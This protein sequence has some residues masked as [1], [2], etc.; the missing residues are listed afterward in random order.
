MG[1]TVDTSYVVDYLREDEGALTKSEELDRRKEPKF[2]STPV[3]YE[4]S[5]GLLHRRSRSETAAFRA[6]A[7]SFVL[8]PFDETAAVLA[9]EVRAE[10]L[11]LGRVKGN[12]DVMIAGIAAAGGHSLITRDE[13]FLAIAETITLSLESY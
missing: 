12:V 8:L 7:S 13:D 10:L 11:R 2:L 3:L 4:I 6:L 5:A 1:I 9:A